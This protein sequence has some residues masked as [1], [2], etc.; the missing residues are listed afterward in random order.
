MSVVSTDYRYLKYTTNNASVN[1]P[2][3]DCDLDSFSSFESKPE[4]PSRTKS[5][6]AS[7]KKKKKHNVKVYID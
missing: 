6:A 5:V 1:H 7:K 3:F 4:P 2:S